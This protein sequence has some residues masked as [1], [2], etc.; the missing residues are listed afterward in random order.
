MAKLAPPEGGAESG[1]PAQELPSAASRSARS[2]LSSFLR[3]EDVAERADG[4][5]GGAD[6]RHRDAEVALDTLT[7]R[8]SDTLQHSA[9]LCQDRPTLP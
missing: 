2:F 1:R 9:L 6:E 5:G 7:L 8:H 3:R 4:E